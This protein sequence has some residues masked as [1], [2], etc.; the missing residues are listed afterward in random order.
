MKVSIETEVSIVGEKKPINKLESR[1]ISPRT[2]GE[3]YSAREMD[4]N[5]IPLRWNSPVGDV[6]TVARFSTWS[7]DLTSK[8]RVVLLVPRF[9]AMAPLDIQLYSILPPFIPHLP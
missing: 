2:H 9:H 6:D 8:S 7:G 5:L 1:N 3:M 4:S